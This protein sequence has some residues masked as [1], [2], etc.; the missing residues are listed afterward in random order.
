MLKDAASTQRQTIGLI[1]F[2]STVCAAEN[3]CAVVDAGNWCVNSLHD[4]TAFASTST[5]YASCTVEPLSI[6]KSF[7]AHS[8]IAIGNAVHVNCT[9]PYTIESD[10]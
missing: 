2:R 9:C 5:S 8:A 10:D 7:A 3:I 1:V 4:F 6:V